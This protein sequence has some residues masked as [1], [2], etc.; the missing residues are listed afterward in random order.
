MTHKEWHIIL[1]IVWTV[2]NGRAEVSLQMVRIFNGIWNKDARPFEICTHGGNFVKN[3]LK[4]GQKW[5]PLNSLLLIFFSPV[6][7]FWKWFE[8]TFLGQ[9]CLIGSVL[10]FHKFPFFFF[11]LLNTTK[12]LIQ[13][14]GGLGSENAYKI[15]LNSGH[16]SDHYSG[17]LNTEHSNSEYIRYQYILKF[18]FWMVGT[19]VPTIPNL[20]QQDGSRFGFQMVGNSDFG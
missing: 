11:K 13:V 8:I 5:I 2:L 4:S 10:L 3:H 14:V 7:C 6:L 18:W 15:H 17:S 19:L 12:L 9:S 1:K 16:S 20:N